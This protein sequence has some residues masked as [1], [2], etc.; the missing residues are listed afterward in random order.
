VLKTSSF[1]EKITGDFPERRHFM[2]RHLRLPLLGLAL[3]VCGTLLSCADAQ[4]EEGERRA[5]PPAPIDPVK[6]ILPFPVLKS[7]QSL[8][9]GHQLWQ[10]SIKGK[11][12]DAEYELIIF[13]PQTSSARGMQVG[14]V[15]VTT[16]M[17]YHLVLKG[18]GEV[19]REQAH[20]VAED[21]VPGAVRDAVAKWKRP[22]KAGN[23]ETEWFAYQEAGAE[24]IYGIHIVV[25]SV[26][27]YHATLKADGTFVEG[28][29]AFEKQ[30][31][32]NP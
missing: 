16:L 13:H 18:T 27:G 25:K 20:P 23:H 9:P 14:P 3:A 8:F 6:N 31:P 29:G 11:G 7:Y 12:D 10:V 32:E 30:P 4:E 22:L 17:N 21:A 24:R 19:I 15:H 5:Q 28:A 2:P 26:E 1:R